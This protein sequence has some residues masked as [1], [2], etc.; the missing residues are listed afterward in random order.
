MCVLPNERKEYSTTI[1]ITIL[2]KVGQIGALFSSYVC[3]CTCIKEA[4]I[5]LNVNGCS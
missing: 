4:K 5:K 3:T 2:C 1:T